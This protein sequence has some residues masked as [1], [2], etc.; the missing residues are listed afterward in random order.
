[1]ISP[2]TT[3][4][5]VSEIASRQQ[6]I[7]HDYRRANGTASRRFHLRPARRANRV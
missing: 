6:Q 7:A 2:T 4:V 1:M 5:L 3:S